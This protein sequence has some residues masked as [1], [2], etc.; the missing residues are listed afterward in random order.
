MAAQQETKQVASI[1]VEIRQESGEVVKGSTQLEWNEDGT[2]SI[3]QDGTDHKLALR[4]E[5]EGKSK[6]LSITVAYSRGGEDIVAPYAF[7]AKV[8]K[9]EVVRIEGN[10]A[11][12]VTVTPTKVAAEK[13][14]K[15]K[16]KPKLDL[17]GDEDDPLAGLD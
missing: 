12:A 3:D 16:D 1:K 5:R 8:K 14:D 10:L 7:D 6:K 17:S 15:G 9:R 2:L 4:V 13:E 11:I